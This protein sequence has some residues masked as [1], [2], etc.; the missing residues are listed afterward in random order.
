ML[1]NG[2]YIILL[3]VVF[4]SCQKNIVYSEYQAVQKA[5]WYQ[6]E[7]LVFDIPV[8]DTVSLYNLYINLRNTKDY[9]YSNLFLIAR[10]SFPDKRQVTDTLEYQMTDVKGNFL[11]QGFSD[12]KE[13]KLFYKENIKFTKPGH[14]IFEVKQAMRNRSEVEP[15]NPLKGVADVGISI[16]KTK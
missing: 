12:V 14:Y 11:G 15:V 16:E 7:V 2:V 10:M 4:E 3:S 9:P 6:N 1:K 13:N 8:Q 5:E